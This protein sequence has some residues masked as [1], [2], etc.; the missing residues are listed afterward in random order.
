MDE[1]QTTTK[2]K[3]WKIII[4]I[5][6]LAI[7]IGVIIHFVLYYSKVSITFFFLSHVLPFYSI[8]V[9]F[10]ITLACIKT[11]LI[12]KIIEALGNTV[13]LSILL[14]IAFKIPSRFGNTYTIPII[15]ATTLTIF[16]SVINITLALIEQKKTKNE[17]A[18]KSKPRRVICVLQITLATVTIFWLIF[19]NY[20]FPTSSLENA[21]PSSSFVI[22]LLLPLCAPFMIANLVMG[23][24]ALLGKKSSAKNFKSNCIAKFIFTL[25]GLLW[26]LAWTLYWVLHFSS[27]NVFPIYFISSICLFIIAFLLIVFSCILFK[28]E[29]MHSK[30]NVYQKNDYGGCVWKKKRQNLKRKK[31]V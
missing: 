30:S 27:F 13:I 15:I 29:L 6:Q 20:V 4:S 9:I 23:I 25:L 2:T 14:L 31:D 28:F 3:K 18:E 7:A 12:K 26:I 8:Y 24:N 17:V 11:N 1:V 19:S 16:L 5:L 22:G 10:N 21:D